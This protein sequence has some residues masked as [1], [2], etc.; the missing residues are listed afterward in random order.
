MNEEE[1]PFKWQPVM[2]VLPKRLEC[3]CGAL[4]VFVIMEDEEEPRDGK[5]D[6][7][8]TGYCQLCFMKE[9]EE[10]INAD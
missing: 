5:R 7:S 2:L 8:Y 1:Q 3:E 6:L 9:Q 4:A 10:I